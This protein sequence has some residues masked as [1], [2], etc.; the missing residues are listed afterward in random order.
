MSKLPSR[1][2]AAGNGIITVKG[3]RVGMAVDQGHR[4]WER[5]RLGTLSNTGDG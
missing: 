3:G 4:H 5:L 2:K 1:M